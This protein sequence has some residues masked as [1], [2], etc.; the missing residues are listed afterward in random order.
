M[1]R[2]IAILNRPIDEEKLKE[3]WAKNKDLTSPPVE[4]QF[5][6]E[7]III[8]VHSSASSPWDETNFC[9]IFQLAVHR[10]DPDCDVHWVEEE[11][12]S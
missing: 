10:V 4:F 3:A 9:T 1:Q 8:I 12:E 11:D 6:G 5:S 7:K 2:F